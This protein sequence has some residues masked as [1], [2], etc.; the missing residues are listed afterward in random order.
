M[1]DGATDGIKA[2]DMMG[3][4]VGEAARVDAGMDG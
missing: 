4:A 2:G 3:L 1:G